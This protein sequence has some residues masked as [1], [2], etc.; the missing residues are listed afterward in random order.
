[1]VQNNQASRCK[2]WVTRS[3]VCSFARTAH[4]F[5][6]SGL[7][8]SLAPS[9]ALTRLLA[10]SLHSLPRSWES[11]FSMSQNDLVLSYSAWIVG[12]IWILYDRLDVQFMKRMNLKL[13]ILNDCKHSPCQQSGTENDKKSRKKSFISNHT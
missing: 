10:R 2:Y 4:L 9:A 1:M 12:N 8:A 6:C 11:E 5:A 13:L 7:L 3:S